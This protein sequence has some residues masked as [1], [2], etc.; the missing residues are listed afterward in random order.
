MPKRLLTVLCWLLAGS[1]FAQNDTVSVVTPV[2]EWYLKI[3]PLAVFEIEGGIGFSGEYLFVKPKL[4]IQLEIQP[5]FFSMYKNY[6]VEEPLNTLESGAPLGIELRPEIRYYF[7]GVRSK[8]YHKR[9]ILRADGTPLHRKNELRGYAAVDFLYKYVQRERLGEL[10]VSNGGIQPPFRQRAVF[11]DVKKITGFDVKF[12]AV[13]SIS[14][15]NQWFIEF[16]AGLGFRHKKF[17]YKDLPV[18]VSE[19]IRGNPISF[20]GVRNTPTALVS[21]RNA[22]S[23]PAGIKLVYRL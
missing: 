1:A 2:N 22:S 11:T 23:L 21:E 14:K 6:S 16:F 3:N 7:D 19:P 4:G 9:T 10:N 12:G 5:V 20:F 13:A 15:S 18:G 8:K 17:S